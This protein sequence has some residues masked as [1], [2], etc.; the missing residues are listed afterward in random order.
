MDPVDQV[1]ISNYAVLGNN[2][3]VL[4]DPLG[5]QAGEG[6]PN[7]YNIKPDG[8]AEY[9][10]SDGGNQTDYLHFEAPE[11][12]V[13]ETTNHVKNLVRDV[14]VD[15]RNVSLNSFQLSRAGISY[16]SFMG[17]QDGGTIARGPVYTISMLT[18]PPRN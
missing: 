10:N 14:A 6:D 3:T 12:F 11:Q 7:R 16:T 5:D 2:P 4:T 18:Q 9:V 17:V 13:P 15:V 8:S 1:S